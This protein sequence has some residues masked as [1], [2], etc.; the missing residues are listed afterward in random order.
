[1]YNVKRSN[2][3]SFIIASAL[4]FSGFTMYVSAKQPEPQPEVMPEVL[5]QATTAP[6]IAPTSSPE[7]TESPTPTPRPTVK[8]TPTPSAS[9][10]P[11]A[12]PTVTPSPSPTAIP[13][14]EPTS[15]PDVWSPANLEPWFSQYS[16]QYGVDKNAL[17]RIAN[18]ESHFNPNASNGD[19]VGMFQFATQTWIN[20]RNQM[21]M[22]PK[23]ALRTNAEE[24][25]RTGAFMMSKRGTTPWPSCV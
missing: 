18:C 17:E 12:I 2:I 19:Y 11:T 7:P 14:P 3:V 24:S 22:D 25:I 13:I 4:S 8:P 6:T 20:Y 9:P 16:G 1:M 5:S 23:P 21:G 15:T 10:T